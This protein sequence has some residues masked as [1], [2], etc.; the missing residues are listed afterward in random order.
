MLVLQKFRHSLMEF[1]AVSGQYD[2]D[3]LIAVPMNADMS[4]RYQS[5]PVLHSGIYLE[6]F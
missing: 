1:F 4:I 6:L 2:L 3:Q 5:I